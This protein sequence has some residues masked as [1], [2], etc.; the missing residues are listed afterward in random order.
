MKRRKTM[1]LRHRHSTWVIPLL[2]LSL[3]LIVLSCA[4]AQNVPRAWIDWPR[5]GFETTVGTTVTL[6]GHAYAENG[7]AEARLEVDRQPYRVGSPE[8]AG[9]QFVEV[10]IDWFAD[11]PG[12]YLLSLV[13]FDANG[14]ASNPASVAVSVT[15]EEP[16]L[17]VTPSPVTTVMTMTLESPTVAP[18]T[19]EPPPPTA[20]SASPATGTPL[21][22]TATP[23]PPRIVV[24]EVDRP[25][26]TAGECVRFSWRVEGYPTAIYFDGQGVTSP[27]SARVCPEATRQFELRAE[28]PSGADAQSITLVVVEPSPIPDTEGPPAPSLVSPTG[29]MEQGCDAVKLRWRAVTDPSGISTYYV[30]VEKVTGT[31]KSGAWTTND[32]ELTI[33]VAWLECG[34]GYEW[35][36]RAEDGAGNLGPLS[37][38]G[39]FTVTLS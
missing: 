3:L 38:W 2:L 9:G 34:Q 28:G 13:A 25:Q 8:P 30:K 31:A 17:L 37:N 16:G 32:T 29:N 5:D 10:S 15:G 27:S 11:E 21:P 12:T 23:E 35:A 26:I 7:V 18:P 20:T 19:S 22:P 4:P 14:Q 36:V 33:P 6:I 24:F 1:R 39:A